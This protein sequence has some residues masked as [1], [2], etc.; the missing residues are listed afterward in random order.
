MLS[1]RVFFISI[2][3]ATLLLYFILYFILF[4]EQRA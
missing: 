3:V 1:V 4:E 2:F